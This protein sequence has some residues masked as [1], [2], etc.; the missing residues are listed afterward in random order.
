MPVTK[1]R[2]RKTPRR[3][4]RKPLGKTAMTAAER[5][6]KRRARLRAD[7]QCRTLMD[8]WD[9]ASPDAQG[10]FLLE[11][12]RQWERFR[13]AQRQAREQNASDY[14]DL[15]SAKGEATARWLWRNCYKQEAPRFE[16]PQWRIVNWPKGGPPLIH[17]LVMSPRQTRAALRRAVAARMRQRQ[18]AAPP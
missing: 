9:A 18:D 1:K 11:L 17:P 4:G 6:R 14:A 15:K 12:R 10:R 7:A 2:P 16:P 5:Q 8:A 13:P 3:R